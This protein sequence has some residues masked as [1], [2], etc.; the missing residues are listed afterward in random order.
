MTNGICICAGRKL[1]LCGLAD[2]FEVIVIS[3]EFKAHKPDVEIFLEGARQLESPPE[4][5]RVCRRYVRD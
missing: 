3:G 1:E 4:E 5:N 2:L